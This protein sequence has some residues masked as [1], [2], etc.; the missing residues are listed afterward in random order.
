[1]WCWPPLHRGETAVVR[2]GRRWEAAA[3]GRFTAVALYEV[4]LPAHSGGPGGLALAIALVFVGVIVLG[5]ATLI[6]FAAG[7][8]SSDDDDDGG[9]GD[10]R[11]GDEGGGPPMPPSPRPQC[12]PAWWPE[13]ERQ[14]AAH[15]R[16][17]RVAQLLR[18][19][20]DPARP[21]RSGA[22]TSPPTRARG[23][24]AASGDFLPSKG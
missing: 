17:Q 1:M 2:R 11:R 9:G 18:S 8:G 14:F 6:V 16:A 5:C 15:V 24:T 10:D 21:K 7:R 20:S 12:D 23:R 3:V 4:E 13:F 22:A 19:R